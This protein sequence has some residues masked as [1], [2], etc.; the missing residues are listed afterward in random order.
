M[1]SVAAQGSPSGGDGFDCGDHVAFDA[2]DLVGVLVGLVAGT[3]FGWLGI[4][5]LGR[6][7]RVP[8]VRFAVNVP[9]TLGMLALAVL[10]AALASVLPGRRAAKASPTEALADI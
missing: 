8:E 9:Q 3:F 6:T 4:S 10:A 7:M 1:A 5:A 2:G